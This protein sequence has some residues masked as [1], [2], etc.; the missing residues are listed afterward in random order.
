MLGATVEVP[1]VHGRVS[2]KIPAG[3]NSGSRLRLKG[4]GIEDHKTGAAGDQYV[5]MRVVL[6]DQPDEELKSFVERWGAI[7]APVE[8]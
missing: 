3:S 1:T 6:P 2:M 4:K 5:T 8:G 7:A